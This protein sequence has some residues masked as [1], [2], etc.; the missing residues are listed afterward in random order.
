MLHVFS[1]AV[2]FAAAI[3]SLTASVLF[4]LHFG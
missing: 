3:M 4:D 2:V 1:P